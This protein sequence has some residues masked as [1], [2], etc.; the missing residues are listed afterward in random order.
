[1]SK[2]IFKQGENTSCIFEVPFLAPMVKALA[3]LN[4]KAFWPFFLQVGFSATQVSWRLMD[5]RPSCLPIF[6]FFCTQ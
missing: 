1:M 2:F 6:T 5:S 4:S 3:K